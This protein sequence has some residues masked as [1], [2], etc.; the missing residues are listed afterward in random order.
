[1]RQIGSLQ[2][3]TNRENDTSNHRHY[4]SPL[5]YG[6]VVVG[7]KFP[8]IVAVEQYDADQAKSDTNDHTEVRQT[9]HAWSHAIDLAKDDTVR[10]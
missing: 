10:C 6:N 3:L 5:G 2:S 8:D 4:Q 7:F 1:M 9:A